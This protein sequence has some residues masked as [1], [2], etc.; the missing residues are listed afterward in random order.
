[1][2]KEIL[3]GGMI[4]LRC[5]GRKPMGIVGRGIMRS[6]RGPAAICAECGEEEAQL[7]AGKIERDDIQLVR[8]HRLMGKLPVNRRLTGGRYA[9][10]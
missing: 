10:R 5:L 3:G 6:R 4:C 1:M 8:E 9:P 7:D 2:T